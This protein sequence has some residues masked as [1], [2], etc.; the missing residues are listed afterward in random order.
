MSTK[1]C[2]DIGPTLYGGPSN[3]IY[4]N[5]C[6]VYKNDGIISNVDSPSSYKGSSLYLYN[7]SYYSVFG[8]VTWNMGE[9]SGTKL[10]NLQQMQSQLNM[11]YKSSVG[12]LPK[13]EQIIAW[14]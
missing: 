6:I 3:R 8:N 13:D 2:W 14:A 5:K 4:G 7:N 10:Y 9:Q 11:E 12:T 1:S